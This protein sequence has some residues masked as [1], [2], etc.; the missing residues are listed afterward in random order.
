MGVLQQNRKNAILLGQDN[1]ALIWLI[2]INAVIFLLINFLK[3]S[4][5]MNYETNIEAS[6][7]FRMQIMN[8][9]TLSGH[10]PQL[11]VKPWTVFTY[12]FTHEDIWQMIGTTL[13]LWGF[14]YILQDLAGN[15]KLVPIY[16]YGGLAGSLAFIVSTNMLPKEA[17]EEPLLG[18]APAIMALAVAVTFLAPKYRLFPMINGGV[19]LWVLTAVFILIDLATMGNIRFISAHIAGGIVG[20]VYAW[21]LEKGNDPGLWMHRFSKW[22]SNLFNPEKKYQKPVSKQN[23]YRATRKPFEKIPHIT[24]QRL[25]EILDKINQSGFNSLAQEE[26]DFLK[27]ASQQDLNH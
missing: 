9:V 3:V 20:L 4:Y 25:D 16:L 19:P 5:F 1:N 12:M 10:L 24:Q 6:Q 2:V 26:K 13:W 7:N 18:G 23:F 27:N 8:W 21:Q 15:S 14:G 17:V 11:E 22:I